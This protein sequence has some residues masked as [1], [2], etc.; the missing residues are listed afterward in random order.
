MTRP[1]GTSDLSPAGLGPDAVA[2]YDP[3][4]MTG[5]VLDQPGQLEDALWRV[6][7][8]SLPRDPAPGG[9]VVCGMGGSGVGADLA[10]GI[11]GPDLRRP[12]VAVRGYALPAW[13]GP[14][15]LVLASSYSGHTEEVLACFEAAGR[16]G[17]RR[18]A[19]TTGGRLAEAARAAGVPVVGVPS[20]LQPRAAVAY[21]TVG[22]LECAAACGA[23][24]ARRGEV[25]DAAALLEGLAA[26]W[27]P[28]GPEDGEAKR[29]ARALRGT[30]PIVFGAE[31]TAPVARRWK[32]QLNENAK[33]FS[34]AAELPESDHNEV[35]AWDPDRLA[36]PLGAVLLEDPGS[37]PRVVR[38]LGLTAEALGAGARAL[39]RVTAPGVNRTERV[40]AL[41]L[42]GDLVSVYLALLDGIDPTPVVAIQRLK[43]AL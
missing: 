13:A 6:A 8:A 17:A 18:V 40:L 16:A 33:L 7:S 4:G 37:H 28:E 25:E 2:R 3:S 23:A 22:A 34:A 15:H 42:L 21:S 27:G 41:V 5:D 11:L 19:L 24:P 35:C 10:A 14:D 38:R 26:E 29:L 31:A 30:H 20:G 36:A 32:T 1:A 9:L 43:A 12:L 39:E